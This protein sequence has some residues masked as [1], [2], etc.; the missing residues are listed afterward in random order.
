MRE[1]LRDN[2]FN[3]PTIPTKMVWTHSSLKCFRT[4]KRKFFWNYI[5]LLRSMFQSYNLLIGSAFHA[6]LEEWYKNPNKKMSTIVKKVY[7]KLHTEI[8]ATQ[9]FYDAAEFDKADQALHTFVGMCM[10]YAAHYEK[11]RK[12]FTRI[13]CEQNFKIDFGDFEY[14]GQID[15]LYRDN[16]NR[17]MENKTTSFLTQTYLRRL[18]MD[19]QIRGYW[20]GSKEDVGI[21]NKSCTYNI[22]KKCGLRRKGG[23]TQN[24][25]NQR[26]ELVYL[27]KPDQYFHREKIVIKR[28]EVERFVDNMRITDNEYQN[29]ITNYDATLPE[30][31]GFND[32]ACDAYFR[33]CDYFELCTKGLDWQSQGLFEQRKTMHHELEEK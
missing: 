18:E 24:E 16:R 12:R 9:N 30:A 19:N 27:E 15:M 2:H 4:C 26:I 7:K 11:D 17:F 14:A 33:I 22:T 6:A 3:P 32:G 28:D 23:E 13:K 10:G 25:F 5:M 8:M 1:L 29:I 21:V 20:L 31:W